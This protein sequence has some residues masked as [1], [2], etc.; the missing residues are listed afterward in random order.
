MANEKT[1]LSTSAI[2]AVSENLEQAGAAVKDKIQSFV[3]MAKNGNTRLVCERFIVNLLY[4]HLRISSFLS[5]NTSLYPSSIRGLALF[6]ALALI[7]SSLNELVRGIFTMH[8]SSALIGLYS[9]FIGSVAVSMEVDAEA[10]PYGEKIRT[11]LLKYLGIVQISTGR[12][13][14]YLIAG[15]LQLTQVNK[16][17]MFHGTASFITYC[18]KLFLITWVNQLTH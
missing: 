14:F 10:V 16:H 3:E 18:F 8:P 17:Q 11:W 13:A 5:S 6:A 9:L 1:P 15:T 12:G 4:Q 2:T 7:I